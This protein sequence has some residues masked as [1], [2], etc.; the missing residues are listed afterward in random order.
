MSDAARC[1][2]ATFFL[3]LGWASLFGWGAMLRHVVPAVAIS[4]P[5]TV[6]LGLSVVLAIGGAINLAGL[7]YAPTL[8]IIASIGLVFCVLHFFKSLRMSLLNS[9]RSLLPATSAA[10][11]EA[12]LTGGFISLVVGFTIVTQLPPHLFTFCAHLYAHI[13]HPA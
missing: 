11:I 10:W 8:W 2:N 12:I 13:S 5:L 3:L 9:R 1:L 7:S 6:A 4:M